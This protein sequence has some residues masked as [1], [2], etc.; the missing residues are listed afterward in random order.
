MTLLI[1]SVV[2]ATRRCRR[3]R[4]W[5]AAAGLCPPR[6]LFSLDSMLWTR[7][8]DASK[9]GVWVTA[10]IAKT[11]GYKHFYFICQEV[12]LLKGYFPKKHAITYLQITGFSSVQ[13]L[14]RVWLFAVSNAKPVNLFKILF[15]VFRREKHNR[16]S[17]LTTFLSSTQTMKI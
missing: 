2:Q 16:P 1:I 15:L 4:D 14:S 12:V 17:A 13:S 7:T 5:F 3:S 10:H 8:G 6:L 11:A 9:W